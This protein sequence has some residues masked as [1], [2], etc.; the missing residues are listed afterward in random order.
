MFTMGQTVVTIRRLK[1]VD[2]ERGREL[3]SLFFTPSAT[4]P[5]SS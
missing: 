4:R 3:F 5:G 2:E 1:V